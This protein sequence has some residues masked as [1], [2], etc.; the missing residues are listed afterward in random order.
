MSRSTFLRRAPRL[1]GLLA[2][3]ALIAPA[4][5]QAQGC[6]HVNL[7]PN[8]G[9]LEAV[10]GAVLCLHNAERARH[11]LRPLRENPSLRRAADR[12][13][14]HMVGAR[15]F[16]HTSPGGRGM[17][18]RVRRTGYTSVARA[19]SLGENIAWGSGRLA[20]AAQMHR[21][22]MRSPGHR[23]NILRGAFREIGIGVEA[24]VPV[25]LSASQSGATYTTNFGYRR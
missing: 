12:H 4:G 25:R 11:G 13:A 24:G 20:T 17:V 14:S 23:S 16:D 5:A 3:G 15:F 9:N 1:A 7:K 6:A 8:R 10:R 19:W 18:D 2:L 22:W 21:G